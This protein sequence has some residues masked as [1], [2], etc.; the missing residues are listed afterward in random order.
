MTS[1]AER[2]KHLEEAAVS[3]S[4]PPHATT[5]PP[6]SNASGAPDLCQDPPGGGEGGGGNGKA[7]SVELNQ[8]G[9][10]LE[11][12][13]RA[14]EAQKQRIEAIFAKHRQR[15]GRSAFLQLQRGGGDNGDGDNTDADPPPDPPKAPSN[16][17]KPASR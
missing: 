9:A 12:K 8:L 10:R 2:K 6:T 4:P 3:G 13:R 5:T 11:E 15:L 1:F 14:I 16:V 7:L 17:G